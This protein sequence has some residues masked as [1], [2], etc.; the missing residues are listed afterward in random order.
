[1]SHPRT[2]WALALTGLIPFFG[3]AFVLA[4]VGGVWAGPGLLALL[5]WAAAVLAFLGGTRW[6]NG[7]AD[8]LQLTIG[9][10]A[11]FAGWG[12][13]AAP[14]AD[15]RWQIGG[16]IV[17]F[18]VMVLLERRGEPLRRLRLTLMA[19]AVAS[20]IVALVAVIRL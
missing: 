1:M 19:G 10:L 15:V 9:W 11:V 7:G 20:L 6:S 17:A 14:I 3:A 12:L 8:G 16:F 2:A 13:L 5:A 18:I 4:V